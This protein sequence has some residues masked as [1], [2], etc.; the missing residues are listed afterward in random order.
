MPLDPERI[1]H[2]EQVWLSTQVA[3]SREE[4]DTLYF[5]E[6]GVSKGLA[7]D[8]ELEKICH[9]IGKEIK[10]KYKVD[11]D[12]LTEAGLNR[13]EKT[14]GRCV[15]VRFAARPDSNNQQVIDGSGA[16]ISFEQYTK[17]Q[18]EKE[19]WARFAR[20][21]Q[22]MEEFGNKVEQGYEARFRVSPKHSRDIRCDDP[23]EVKWGQRLHKAL[24]RDAK[25][26]VDG[27]TVQGSEGERV[28]FQP[29]GMPEPFSEK[30]NT[31][32]PTGVPHCLCEKAPC[33]GKLK[34]W[35]PT[36]TFAPGWL[37]L[38]AQAQAEDQP[39]V[40]VLDRFDQSDGKTSYELRDIEEPESEP[41]EGEGDDSPNQ[42]DLGIEPKE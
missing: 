16:G 6:E 17:E 18:I 9:D 3:I 30:V 1:F 31:D 25:Q 40:L 10:N 33:T 4:A 39:V 13:E 7:T 12:T 2:Q 20:C 19:F 21:Q 24:A 38:L 14:V 32:R 27:V 22:L 28:T 35:G 23:N 34:Q 36:Y 42:Q 8:N 41:A 29:Q 15:W 26:E 11:F 5:D 37:R